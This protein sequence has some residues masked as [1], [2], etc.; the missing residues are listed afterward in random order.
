MT[1]RTRIGSIGAMVDARTR[2]LTDREQIGP[3]LPPSGRRSTAPRDTAFG[4]SGQAHGG[5]TLSALGH[6]ARAVA[7]RRR[8][9]TADVIRPTSGP[10]PPRLERAMGVSRALRHPRLARHQ[11][12]LRADEA[13]LRVDALPAA[14]DCSSST[15]SRS[16]TLRRSRSRDSRTRCSRSPGLTLWIFVSR[17]MLTGSESLVANIT[18]VT[19]TSCTANPHPARRQRLGDRRLP[20][21][22]F[23][24]YLVISAL[25]GFYPDL[26]DRLHRAAAAR[27]LHADARDLALPLGDERPLPRRRPGAAVPRHALVLPQPG[28][29]SAPDARVVVADARPGARTRWSG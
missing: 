12:P 19:K 8:H 15:R 20:R 22:R 9:P 2:Q 10:I 6:H 7:E 1:R 13:R 17:A 14:R 5:R 23:V 3:R 27:R 16:P 21:S 24:L 18:I 26:D 25:Y 29:V 4:P 11:G 28:R